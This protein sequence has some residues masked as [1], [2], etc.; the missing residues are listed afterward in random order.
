MV[1]IIIAR[2]LA[3]AIRP[4]PPQDQETRGHASKRDHQ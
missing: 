1:S 2:W 3:G 4:A